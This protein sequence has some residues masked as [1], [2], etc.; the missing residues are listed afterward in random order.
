MKQEFRC[1]DYVIKN[2]E[3]YKNF[4]NVLQVKKCILGIKLKPQGRL[5]QKLIG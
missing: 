5:R 2:R 1:M 3:C 4:G